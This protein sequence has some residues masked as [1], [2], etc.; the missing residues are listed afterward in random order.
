MEDVIEL[1]D[2]LD[3][4]GILMMLDFSKAFDCL[5]WNFLYAVL[6]QFNFGNTFIHWIRTLYDD[7]ITC[8]KNNGYLS[9]NISIQ[10]GIRQ[11][12]PV[13]ALLFIIAT[14][15]MS[16][17]IRSNKQLQGLDIPGSDINVKILQYADNVKGPCYS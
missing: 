16:I 13:S 12:C 9:R 14:E 10:R 11:G 17:N 4:E 3:K 8:I 15:V 1:Y 5:E 7:P 6:E 2:K